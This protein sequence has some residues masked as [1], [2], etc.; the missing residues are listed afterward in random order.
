MRPVAVRVRIL[1]VNGRHFETFHIPLQYRLNLVITFIGHRLGLSRDLYTA[2]TY[3]WAH[4]K[5]PHPACFA[6]FV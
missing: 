6:L 2:G 5:K 4:R 3:C 1:S